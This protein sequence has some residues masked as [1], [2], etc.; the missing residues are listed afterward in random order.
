MFYAV[1]GLPT[2]RRAEASTLFKAALSE[3]LPELFKAP[4][5]LLQG[6]L[7]G[8][9]DAT[10]TA[11]I[12]EEIQVRRDIDFGA[13]S[14]LR[15]LVANYSLADQFA[16][17]D[18][19]MYYQIFNRRAIEGIGAYLESRHVDLAEFKSQAGAIIGNTTANA[20]SIYGS[21]AA[22]GE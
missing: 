18:E 16:A 15:E 2:D 3:S 19:R 13:L 11:A 8:R 12:E 21:A 4:G 7:S 9:A 14:S 22:G 5:R 20:Q 6:Y 1:R 17:L 10:A